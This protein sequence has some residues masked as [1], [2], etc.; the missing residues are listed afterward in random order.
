[1]TAPG[2]HPDPW[3]P[4]ALR[5][6]DGTQW[7]S[8]VTAAVQA[9]RVQ[10]EPANQESRPTA[11]DI[12]KARVWGQRASVTVVLQALLNC[13]QLFLAATAFH[14]FVHDWFHQV[15]EQDRAIANAP[16]GTY[17]DFPIHTH[18]H[19]ITWMLLLGLAMW[20]LQIALMIWLWRSA[21]I[22]RGLGMDQAL[23]PLWAFFGFIVPVIGFWFP[24]TVAAD[25][26]QRGDPERSNVGL[27]WG[28]YLAQGAAGIPVFF[29]SFVSRPVSLVLAGMFCAIP[30]ACA[31]RARHMISALTVRQATIA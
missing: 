11:D 28:L 17:P 4:A 10:Q 6:W 29:I 31:W 12:A 21:K 7:T 26:F 27:W 25:L 23:D 5:W 19:F 3:S 13:V 2:W 18:Y 22:G 30:L 9:Y 15:N 1:M 20:L 8:H 14:D 16:Y 24:Y